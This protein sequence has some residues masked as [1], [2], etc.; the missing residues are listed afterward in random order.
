MKN[1]FG[2][3]EVQ[4]RQRKELKIVL[5]ISHI[6]PIKPKTRVSRGLDSREITH[7]KHH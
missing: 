6:S 4:V 1:K 2:L 5:K 7:E 3:R